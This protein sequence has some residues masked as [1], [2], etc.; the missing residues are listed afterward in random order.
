VAF[1]IEWR[2]SGR[3][4]IS[5]RTICKL[6]PKFARWR[7]LGP[8]LVVDGIYSVGALGRLPGVLESLSLEIASSARGDHWERYPLTVRGLNLLKVGADWKSVLLR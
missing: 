6:A 3:G 8:S 4:A 5:G 1:E 2:A 7:R